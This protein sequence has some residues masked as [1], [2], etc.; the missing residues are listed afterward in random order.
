MAISQRVNLV[1]LICIIS[2]TSFCFINQAS[3]G[4][5]TVGSSCQYSTISAAISAAKPGDRLLIEGFVTFNE[6]ITIDKNLTLEGGYTK[7]A[8]GLAM[9]TTI[10][11]GGTGR[12]VSINADL[13]VTLKNLIITN[14]ISTSSGG[15]IRC[16]PGTGGGTLNLNTVNIYGNTAR[17]GGGL[18]VSTGVD[19]TAD[20]VYIQNN[21]A[22]EFG[23]GA[24]LYGGRAFF[25]NSRIY[26]NTAPKGA[27]IYASHT[28]T[29]FPELDLSSSTLVYGNEAL[30]G[31]GFGGGIYM[32]DGTISLAGDCEI[33][34]NS[35][36]S[37]GG[38]YA[39]GSTT[40]ID[41]SNT[42]FR[43]NAASADGGGIYINAGDLDFT[44]SWTLRQN[45]AGNNGGAIAVSGTADVDFSV[46]AYS[47]VYANQ[48]LG[49]HGGMLYLG[50]NT[51][52]DLMAI[53]GS[54][55]YVYANSANQNGG[56]LYAGSGG[57]FD[58][59]GGVNF[60]RNRADNGGA[61]YVS[62]G[63]KVW[64]DDYT[65]DFRPQVWDNRADNGNGGAIY[66]V[67][68]PN[69]QC[70]GAIFGKEGEGNQASVNGGAIYLN[71]SQFDADNCI[72][73]ENQ[74]A[75]NGG[76]IAA[77]N[78]SSLSIYATFST[79]VMSETAASGQK[80]VEPDNDRPAAS[81]INPLVEPGSV[82]SCNVADNDTNDTGYGGGIYVDNSELTISYT[83]FFE[84]SAVQGGAIYQKGA[85][86]ATDI[87]NTLIYNNTSTASIGGGVRSYGGTLTMT[88]VTLV[89][90]ING[91]GYSQSNTDATIS[92]SI[93]WGND[94]GGFW[95]RSGTM[96]GTCNI[97][98][99]GNIGLA[100]DPLFVDAGNNDFH[101]K[102]GSP[103]IDACGS[104]LSPDLENRVR[105]QNRGFDM[106]V[107]ESL[108]EATETKGL[109]G[110]ILLL[111]KE[112]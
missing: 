87:S 76:A 35:A 85:S 75:A 30:T 95:E 100:V 12:V 84:N 88:H 58:I 102:N 72:F 109:P 51:T 111:L 77:E 34:E 41:I 10:N 6:N 82:F 16:A 73:E 18:W 112:D 80:A 90:N 63:S 50:N 74:A 78:N 11:G 8:S 28:T 69:V 32:D 93:A 81:G 91:A 38:I 40:D 86:V 37:G 106:G 14:G 98:Q 33:Y 49:G 15:G 70:D 103:A 24:R 39:T 57:F 3:A 22:A 48:A 52:V 59:Y 101:L 9:A 79:P 46:G 54:S 29:F 5:L 71:N 27:G 42:T 43:S 99:S 65:R 13:N 108:W 17:W 20:T 56:A 67:D 21:T 62:N 107:Y 96:N 66:A 1:L 7:C 19:V 36:V 31:D 55:V 105:P 4:D 60:D 45:S 92:N 94:A 47:L 25:S 26:E 104:G 23:G 83:H 61:V 2:F 64:M 68:S 97:D 53:Q 89:N 44:D 110:V